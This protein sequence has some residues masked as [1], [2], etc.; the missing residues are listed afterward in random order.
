M[1]FASLNQK[2]D[3]GVAKSLFCCRAVSSWT[4]LAC[5]FLILGCGDSEQTV[6]EVTQTAATLEKT[7]LSHFEPLRD[8]LNRLSAERAL[9]EQ[10]DARTVAEVSP[11]SFAG[12]I[13][14]LLED[15]Q[16]ERIRERL[17]EFFPPNGQN[18]RALTLEKA[19]GFLK[20]YQARLNEARKSLEGPQDRFQ[21]KASDGWFIDTS[22]A[23]KAHAIC[24]LELIA[25]MDAISQGKIAETIDSLGYAGRIIRM[26]ANDEHL[27]ARLTAVSLRERWL[28]LISLTVASPELQ[29]SDLEKIYQLLLN[30][31]SQWPNESR[32]WIVDRAI[33][34]QTYELVRQGNYLSLLSP[35]EAEE[36]ESEGLHI[37]RSRAVQR[38]IDQ[39]ESFYLDTMRRIIDAESMPFYMRDSTWDSIDRSIEDAKKTEHYPQ[40]AIELLLPDI[41]IAQRQIADDRARVEAWTLVLAHCVGNNPPTYQKNPATGQEYQVNKDENVVEVQGL[42]PE[43]FSRRVVAPLKN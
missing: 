9:P 41:K 32:A 39:D 10:L 35:E 37:I 30:Q 36:L 21:W 8:E 27:V 11:K 20:F 40:V 23:D 12:S 4:V 3:Q 2:V 6:T 38:Y 19:A 16:S 31:I 14:T 26:L 13:D 15:N 17:Q 33:G 25:G 34:L 18:P 29:R 28:N 1:P 5:C 43:Q 7:N 42:S 22:Y 24:G